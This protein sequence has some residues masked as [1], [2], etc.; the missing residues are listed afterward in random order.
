VQDRANPVITSLLL[1]PL[2]GV[3]MFKEID[4]TGFLAQAH[5]GKTARTHPA[6]IADPAASSRS[7]S[8]ETGRHSTS[9]AALLAQ[10]P[11]FAPL[12]E[13]E[14]Q[15]LVAQCQLRRYKAGQ[16]LFHQGDPGHALYLVQSGQ[17]KITRLAADGQETILCIAGPGACV[18]EMALL[19]E[20]PRSA[21]VEALGPVEALLLPREAFLAL[22]EQRPAVARAVMRE[23]ARMIRHTSEQVQDLI[24]LDV[25]GRIAKV[26]LILAEQ[27]GQRGPEGI[28]IP[29]PFSREEF[30]KLV[31][32]AR[33]TVSTELCAF[34][35]R[36][37]LTVDREGITLHQL[38]PL[39]KRIE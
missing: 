16:V 5:A 28:R 1:V 25:P 24:R 30:A 14:L 8:P 13:S 17:V 19:D 7:T 9:S 10:V 26:L 33:T 20:Q 6:S 2:I 12:S 23:L 31:G 29:L 4:M 11:Y 15:T 21:T 22:L 18:G 32:A 3:C 39:R 34:Q 36:G 37:L 27:H 38:A 35:E